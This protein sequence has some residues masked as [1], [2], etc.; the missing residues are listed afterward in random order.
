[1]AYNLIG[2]ATRMAF[3]IGLN[4]AGQGQS[5]SETY[6]DEARRTWCMVYV[7]EVELSLDS[8]RP[9]S[10]RSCDANVPFLSQRIEDDAV[11]IS[12]RRC[13]GVVTTC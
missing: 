13:T 11:S 1:M 2:L 12:T 6:L 9:M 8:G 5:P 4:V 3:S 10:L 7:Q